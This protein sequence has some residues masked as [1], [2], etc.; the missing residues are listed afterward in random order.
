MWL[1]DNQV[2][3]LTR[4][5][6]PSAQIRLL[7]ESGIPFDVV[8]G[9]PVVLKESLSHREKPKGKLILAPLDEEDRPKVRHLPIDKRKR[10]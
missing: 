2:A 8:D 5:K 9:R 3:E 10:G 6:R 4:R 7:A 1:I